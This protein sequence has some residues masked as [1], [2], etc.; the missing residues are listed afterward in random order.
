MAIC[1]SCRHKMSDWVYIKGSDVCDHCSTRVKENPKHSFI[2]TLIM[3]FV[4]SIS[5]LLTNSILWSVI[6]VIG[7]IPFYFLT[8]SFVISEDE[9]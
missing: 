7:L 5:I 4:G 2:W 1:P 6:F 8:K 9:K 3:F